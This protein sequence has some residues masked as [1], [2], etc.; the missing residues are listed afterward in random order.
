MTLKPF[1][2]IDVIQARVNKEAY[3]EYALEKIN[4]RLPKYE[5]PIIQKDRVG[6]INFFKQLLP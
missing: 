6:W 2:I 1:N 4:I 5:K 3:F